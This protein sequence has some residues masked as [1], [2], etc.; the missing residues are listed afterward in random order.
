MICCEGQSAAGETRCGRN[1]WRWQQGSGGRFGSGA[2]GALPG[3]R[4][5]PVL[6]SNHRLA[7]TGS[8]RVKDARVRKP[9]LL[10]EIAEC[11]SGAH[12]PLARNHRMTRLHPLTRQWEGMGNWEEKG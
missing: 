6:E 4:Q 8:V 5:E 7:S 10:K 9:E 12:P 11:A 3:R 1:Y 2:V